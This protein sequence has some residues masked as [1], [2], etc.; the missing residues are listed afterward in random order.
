LISVGTAGIYHFPSKD[1][2]HSDH[3]FGTVLITAERKPLSEITDPFLKQ[4]WTSD[5]E[6]TPFSNVKGALW[7]SQRGEDWSAEQVWGYAEHDIP[8]V[9][10]EKRYTRRI[11]FTSP[12]LTKDVLVIYGQ[13]YVETTATTSSSHDDEDLSSF[14]SS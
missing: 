3:V 14:G 10:R 8:G 12:T 4:G 11:H 2:K 9:G 5:I 7:T 6:T 13:K 1:F